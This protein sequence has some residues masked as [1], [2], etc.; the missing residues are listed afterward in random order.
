MNSKVQAIVSEVNKVTKDNPLIYFS[1]EAERAIGLENI[2]QNYH[3]FC[4]DDS[5]IVDM[6][7]EKKFDIFCTDKKNIN[8]PY[9][10]T[11]DLVKDPRVISRIKEIS[12]NKHFYAQFF[13]YQMP[14]KLLIE[15]IGGSV[16]N[17]SP[18]A[19][20]Q[21]EDKITQQRFF[22]MNDI[23]VP[24]SMV[25]DIS[26]YKYKDLVRMF[27][28]DLVIQQNRSFTGK[29]TYFISDENAYNTLQKSFS[30]N[31]LKISKFI[32]GESYTINGL[33]RKN[34]QILVGPLQYQITGYSQLTSG[35]GSTV[36]NDW[37][38]G[39]ELDQ[40]IKKL[41]NIEV[42]KIGSALFKTD[43]LGHFG[44]DLIVSEEGLPYVIEI[45]GRQ[46]ANASL[47]T[48]LALQQD[49]IPLML[50]HLAEFLNIDYKVDQAEIKD[51]K[52]SQIFLRSQM[53]DFKIN[54]SVKSGI[55]RLQSDNS[56]IDWE[57]LQ[58]KT[59]VIYTDEEMDKPIIWQN[60]G[61]SIDDI[62]EGGFVLLAS[63]M[64]LNKDL[65]E[66]LA[67]MQFTDKIINKGKVDPWILDALKEVKSMMQ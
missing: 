26:E 67:R 37:S 42:I 66:E 35:K 16:V 51:L 59:N 7:I 45:N 41:I 34:G 20:R 1:R 19:N 24:D 25:T 12:N 14:T 31:Q 49:S 62:G 48:K 28:N 32:R 60:D 11:K 2:L 9:R 29:G 18:D 17:N 39:A 56:A 55:Y 36:G 23:S 21:I 10:S 53:P 43:Y 65:S 58:R 30:G 3:I 4:I 52:G 38:V 46:T 33:V 57:T 47:E 8:I 13:Q 64:N 27:D 54:N 63:K 6:L 40:S 44:I 22:L 15:E 5:Y 50:L 61:Y